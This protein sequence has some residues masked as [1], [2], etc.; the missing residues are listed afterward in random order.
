MRYLLGCRGGFAG[1]GRDVEAPVD[2]RV[3]LVLDDASL[4][5]HFMFA[6]SQP[7]DAAY[8]VQGFGQPHDILDF[9]REK[10]KKKIWHVVKTF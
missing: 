9:N 2:R 5:I 7:V 3:H 6:R 1:R 4:R 8:S 10:G